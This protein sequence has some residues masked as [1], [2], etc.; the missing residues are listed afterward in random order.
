MAV[1]Y[2]IVRLKFDGGA[3]SSFE[4][5]SPVF[6]SEDKK[7]LFARPAGIAVASDGSLLVSDDT[8]GV[9]YRVFYQP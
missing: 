8:N 5:F 6:L 3:P 2:K 9:I 4:D 7:S 1:G